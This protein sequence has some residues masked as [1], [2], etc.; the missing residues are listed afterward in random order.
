MGDFLKTPQA[1]AYDGITPGEVLAS[2]AVIVDANEAI[3]AITITDLKLG[4]SGSGVSITSSAAEIN[5]TDGIATNAYLQVAEA[6]SFTETATTGTYTA[7]VAIPSSGTVI[8]VCWSNIA[9]WTASTSATM[10]V[11]DTSNDDG[12]FT[13][14]DLKS[15]PGAGVTISSLVQSTGSGDY[16]GVPK[17]YDADDTISGVVTTEG[18]TGDAGRSIMLVTYVVPTAVAA[19]KA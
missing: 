7:T 18:E 2:K 11:G 19:T 10:K 3:D 9:L 8:D 13:N 16:K 1:A 12:F 14:V 6:R 5:K 15:A 4:E 17:Y